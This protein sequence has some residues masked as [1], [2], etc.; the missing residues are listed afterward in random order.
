MWHTL[1]Y[2]R[3]GQCVVGVVVATR[4]SQT[5]KDMVNRVWCDAVFQTSANR[6]K[7]TLFTKP[8]KLN[9]VRV[10]SQPTQWRKQGQQEN[11]IYI[12]RII[13]RILCMDVMLV[14]V[15]GVGE[16]M[17]YDGGFVCWMGHSM[18]SVLQN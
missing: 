15:G 2:S 4:K 16:I 9:R 6:E 10:S 12:N 14:S 3:T 13:P 5:S 11:W 7:S 18:N 17:C 8:T 1:L